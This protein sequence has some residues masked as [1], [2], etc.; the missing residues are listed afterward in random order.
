M[1]RIKEL[2][3]KVKEKRNQ[4]IRNEILMIKLKIFLTQ[5]DKTRIQK[6]QQE[7]YG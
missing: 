7:L 5:E 3:I 6:L 4:E 2:R 1:S